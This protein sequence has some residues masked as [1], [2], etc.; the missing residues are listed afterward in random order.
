MSPSSRIRRAAGLLA[1]AILVG[2]ALQSPAAAQFDDREAF[3]TAD[4]LPSDQILSR[5]Q[6]GGSGPGRTS[7]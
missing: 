6:T 2:L 5:P 3:T 7:G 1:G 4:G